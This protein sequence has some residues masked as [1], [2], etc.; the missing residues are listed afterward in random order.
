[1][2]D[3]ILKVDFFEE[4]SFNESTI[5]LGIQYLYVETKITS[6][7]ELFKL[8]RKVADDASSKGATR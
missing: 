7:T 5:L 1:M 3:A 8:Q 4:G 2:Q 6:T